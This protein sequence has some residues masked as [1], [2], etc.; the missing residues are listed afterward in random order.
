MLL[1]VARHCQT[2]LNAED[3]IQG[4]KSDYDLTKFGKQQAGYL[5]KV[6]HEELG[7]HK[8]DKIYCSDRKRAVSTAKLVAPESELH[9]D[10]RLTA[11]DIGTAEGVLFEE[12]HHIARYPKPWKY[13]NMENLLGYVSRVKNALKDIAKENKGKVVLLVTHED[14]S[15]VIEKLMMGRSLLSVPKL[16]LNN[17]AFRTYHLLHHDEKLIN[18]NKY[19]E[20]GVIRKE[21]ANLEQEPP[22]YIPIDQEG[23]EVE[24]GVKESKE[25]TEKEFSH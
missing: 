14:V 1:I 24:Y 17:G 5:K 8:I 9:I 23:L 16:G 11:Y 3:R 2:Q 22:K 15:A 12:L 21:Y 10:N 18:K 25:K 7:L 20:L 4:G 6:I 19:Q 13:K